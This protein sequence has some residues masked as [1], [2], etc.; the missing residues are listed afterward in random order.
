MAAN[1]VRGFRNLTVDEVKVIHRAE[2]RPCEDDTI[3]NEGMI[4][5]ALGRVENAILYGNVE[6]VFILA[7]T[8]A[9]GITK[10]HPFYTG[11]KR[12]ALVSAASFIDA[13]GYD[14]VKAD[15]EPEIIG[16]TEGTVSID[17]F[18]ERLR[19]ICVPAEIAEDRNR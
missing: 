5:S 16:L 19:E 12:A 1:T 8:L 18:A 17:Q 15:L 9:H 14:W 10:N 4:H 2:L 3:L 11:N 7:A 13:N 6:D